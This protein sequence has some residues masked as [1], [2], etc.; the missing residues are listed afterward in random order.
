MMM[1]KTIAITTMKNI[2]TLKKI[3]DTFGKDAKMIW[4]WLAVPENVKIQLKVTDTKV[5]DGGDLVVQVGT[6]IN[7]EHKGL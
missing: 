7:E 6:D 1:K 2:A 4:E 5:H 3:D